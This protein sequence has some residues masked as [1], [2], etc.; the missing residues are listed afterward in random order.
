MKNI[1]FLVSLALAVVSCQEEKSGNLSTDLVTHNATASAE[2]VEKALPKM[3]F[4]E[5]LFEF[6]EIVQGEKV[7]HTFTFVNKGDADL[8]ITGARGSCGCTVPTWPKEPIRPGEKGEIFVVFNSEGKEG[9]QHKQ[10]T[11]TANTNPATNYLAISGMVVGPN[12]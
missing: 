8:I 9:K 10:I 3:T 5:D 12:K 7:E 1:V 6:G 4:E 2:P 11:V